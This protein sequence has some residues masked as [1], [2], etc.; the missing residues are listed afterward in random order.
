MASIRSATLE[1]LEPLKKV[2]GEN[3]PHLVQSFEKDYRAAQTTKEPLSGRF[4]VA[5]MEG[6]LVGITGYR[7]D[8]WGAADVWWLMWLYISPTFKR[9]GIAT[10]LFGAAQQ[11][12][13]EL[14]CRKCYLDVG[15]LVTQSAAVSFHERDGFQLEGSLRDFWTPGMHHH[16]FGKHL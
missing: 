16:I 13:R 10:Q 14:G 5:V 4:L 8:A 11:Q 6:R 12:L 3:A 15:D 7:P 1:D 2:V 9:R